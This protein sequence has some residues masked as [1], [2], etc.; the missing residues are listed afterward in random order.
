MS[1]KEIMEKF[2]KKKYKNEANLRINDFKKSF[3]QPAANG[4]VPTL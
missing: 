1:Q 3:T 2:L 4:N